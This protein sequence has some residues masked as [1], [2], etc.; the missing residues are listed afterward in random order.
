MKSK[1]RKL[2]C[3]KT[4]MGKRIKI[5]FKG[6]DWALF[7]GFCF[8]A[9]HFMKNVIDEY[10]A[11][12]TSFTQSLEPITKLPSVVL[13]MKS[14][15][16][17]TYGIHINISYWGNH[18]HIFDMI[19]NKRYLLQDEAEVVEVNQFGAECFKINSTIMQPFEQSHSRT[20]ALSLIEYDAEYMPKYIR[21]Y[22]TS[23]ENSYGNS[24]D[25]WEGNVFEQ[26]LDLETRVEVTL[27]PFE[28]RYLGEGTKCSQQ[29]NIARF[30]SVLKDANFTNCQEKCS[31]HYFVNDIFPPCGNTDAYTCAFNN[32]HNYWLD[33]KISHGYKKPCMVLEYQG[34]KT[35]D[36]DDEKYQTAIEYKFA[37]PMMTNVQQEYLI[38]DTIGMIGSVGG[39]LGMCIGF[40][41]SGVTTYIL[42]FIL[43]RIMNYF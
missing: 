33:F 9:G 14:S 27:K 18:D 36:W 7:I 22:F 24:L 23:E 40:S 19:E 10:Q 30:K 28:Y 1:K 12:K 25:W 6:I 26:R 4:R 43:A 13:C 31:P 21:V 16:D 41:F 32:I 3:Q 2:I 42:D 35:Y 17:W 34:K 8:L 11:K 37:P 29:S 38:F 20:I 5:F 39:T 15:L